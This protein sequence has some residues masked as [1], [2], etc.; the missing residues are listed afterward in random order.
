VDEEEEEE[1]CPT[2]EMG[3]PG[4]ERGRPGGEEVQPDEE[5]VSRDRLDITNLFE[6]GREA[7]RLSEQWAKDR[8]AIRTNS[9]TQMQGLDTV[10]DPYL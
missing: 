9:Q 7:T 3:R 2:G 4:G 5:D 8:S 10:V 1:D 6:N